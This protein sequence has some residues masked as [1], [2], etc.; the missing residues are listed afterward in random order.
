MK[1]KTI[2]NLLILVILKKKVMF[3]NKFNE[4]D[5]VKIISTG[6]IGVIVDLYYSADKWYYQVELVEKTIDR[7]IIECREDDIEKVEYK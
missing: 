2:K 7:D 1:K 6:E 5:K 3:V 4:L